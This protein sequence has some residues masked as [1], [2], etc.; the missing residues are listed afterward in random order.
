ML[1]CGCGRCKGTDRETIVIH[2]DPARVDSTSDAVDDGGAAIPIAWQTTYAVGVDEGSDG[3]PARGTVLQLFDVGSSGA[4][5]VRRVLTSPEDIADVAFA[6]DGATLAFTTTVV[7]S[8]EPSQTLR[9][10]GVDGTNVRTLARCGYECGLVGVGVDGEVWYVN[11]DDSSLIGE[12]QHVSLAGGSA[13]R[14]PHAFAPCAVTGTV[15][16]DGTA[17]LLGVDDSLG[18]PE[19]V[20]HGG[21]GFYVVPIGDAKSRDR[22]PHRIDCFTTH[23]PT[24]INLTIQSLDFDGPDRIVLGVVDGW[25]PDDA[26]TAAPPLPWSCKRDGTDARRLAA[27][28]L[29]LE[30]RTVDGK[31]WVVLATSPDDDFP[32]TIHLRGPIDGTIGALARRK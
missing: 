1:L 25:E 2:E 19:C 27:P 4:R 10:C 13:V 15:S 28:P 23:K 30:R 3:G 20:S 11:R 14:W 24:E 22:L 17:M 18:W 16:A 12:V 31:D 21:Q 26:S 7:V 32:H 29:E 5:N 6:P 8:T 9:A